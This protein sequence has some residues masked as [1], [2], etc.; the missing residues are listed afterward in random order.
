MAL[1]SA[2]KAAQQASRDTGWVSVSSS[3]VLQIRHM[4]HPDNRLFVRFKGGGGGFYSGVPRDLYYQMTRA[5]SKGKFLHRR[6]K[7]T[8]PWTAG[9]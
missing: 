8:Y 9:I 4:G 2:A 7:G 3:N 5:A 1:V 6:L